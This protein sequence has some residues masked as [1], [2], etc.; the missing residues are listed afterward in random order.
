MLIILS[1]AYAQLSGA[2][3]ADCLHCAVPGSSEVL[4]YHKASVNRSRNFGSCHQAARV[5]MTSPG[6]SL[7]VAGVALDCSCRSG[8]TFTPEGQQGMGDALTAG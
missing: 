7:R 3:M 8:K 5:Y 6:M 1:I 4:D 2:K